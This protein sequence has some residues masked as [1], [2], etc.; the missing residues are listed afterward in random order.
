MET[1]VADLQDTSFPNGNDTRA[2]IEENMDKLMEFRKNP[3][4]MR[5]V[6]HIDGLI[7]RAKTTEN[8]LQR[9]MDISRSLKEQCR[10]QEEECNVVEKDKAASKEEVDQLRM[11]VNILIAEKSQAETKLEGLRQEN[12]KLELF[13]EVR[14]INSSKLAKILASNITNT[15]P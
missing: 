6:Q 13:L 7:D 14:A 10:L 15:W 8:D 2:S 3:K 11:R 9:M 5:L 1:T 12:A 4:F